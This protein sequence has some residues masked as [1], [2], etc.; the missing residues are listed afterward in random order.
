M[1]IW[2]KVM[3]R[4]AISEKILEELG[5]EETEGDYL[6]LYDFEGHVQGEFYN[7]LYRIFARGD[8]ELI[9]RSVVKCTKRKT[10]LAIRALAKHYGAKTLLYEVAKHG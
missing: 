1:V 7:N 9:Q 10:A 8:G 2:R 4:K 3:G 5:E 6:V